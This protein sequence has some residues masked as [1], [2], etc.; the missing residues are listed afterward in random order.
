MPIKGDNIFAE[1]AAIN[2]AVKQ[3]PIL[4]GNR[5]EK[6]FKKNFDLEGFQG[7]TGLEQWAQRSPMAA[8]NE[9]RKILRDSGD[10]YNDIEKRVAGN[11]IKVLVAGTSAKYADIHNFGGKIKIR[12]TP[13]MKKWAYAIFKKT[14][15]PFYFN[16]SITNKKIIEID[17]PQ[18]KFIGNSAQLDRIIKDLIE[19]KLL[20]VTTK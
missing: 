16:L 18:R 1:L 2:K 12:V 17:M 5:A 20:E 9:G 19:K 11:R 14:N 4:V 10:L 7:N 15:T 3:L 13:Q 8:R 6:F